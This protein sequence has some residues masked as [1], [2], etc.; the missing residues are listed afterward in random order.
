[1]IDFTVIK[2][3]LAIVYEANWPFLSLL[4]IIGVLIYNFRYELTDNYRDRKKL[5]NAVSG[6]IFLPVI[7]TVGYISIQ[8]YFIWLF[9]AVVMAILIFLLYEFGLLDRFMNT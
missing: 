7:A 2:N 3:S 4:F 9:I 5:F 1:M 8:G 6:F